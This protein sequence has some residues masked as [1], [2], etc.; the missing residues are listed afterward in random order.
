VDFFV[1]PNGGSKTAKGVIWEGWTDVLEIVR[2]QT[3]GGGV[4]DGR[5]VF[6][7]RVSRGAKEVVNME[8]V[9]GIDSSKR[10]E[11]VRRSM[12]TSKVQKMGSSGSKKRSGKKQ[13]LYQNAQ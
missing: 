12:P 10:G 1:E 7:G 6:P 9:V 5:V 13:K 11:V 2:R 4:G 8:E 3:V